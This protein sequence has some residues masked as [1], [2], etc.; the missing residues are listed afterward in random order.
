MV[1]HTLAQAPLW[2]APL[3]AGVL[4]VGLSVGGIV[5]TRWGARLSW[6]GFGATLLMVALIVR[7][8]SGLA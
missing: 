3:A 5:S 1:A 6:A 8:G 2:F 7:S 4:A